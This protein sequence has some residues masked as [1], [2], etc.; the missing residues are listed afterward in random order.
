MIK[1]ESTVHPCDECGKSSFCGFPHEGPHPVFFGITK[2]SAAITGK[3]QIPTP[4]C[5]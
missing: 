4:K 5:V 2:T 3:K 1:N